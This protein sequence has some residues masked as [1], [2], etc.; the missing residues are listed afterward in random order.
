[1]RFGVRRNDPAW[2]ERKWSRLAMIWSIYYFFAWTLGQD[3]RFMQKIIWFG[4]AGV[5]VFTVPLFAK[6]IRFKDLPERGCCSGC[7]SFGR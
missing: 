6:Y 1:M 3:A 7:S 4:A 5:G 2:A